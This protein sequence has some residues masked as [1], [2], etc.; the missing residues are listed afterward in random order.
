MLNRLAVVFFCVVLVLTSLLF[1]FRTRAVFKRNPWVTTFF[2]FLW[3]A[4]LGGCIALIVDVFT[5]VPVNTVTNTPQLCIDSGIN[6]FAA[7]V[8]IIP[9][10]NDTLIFLAT[11]WRL[12]R[13]SYADP[14]TLESGIK[15]FILG[16]HLPVFSKV[17][18]RDGQ[19]YYLLALFPDLCPH[20]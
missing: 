12:S 16:D 18:L 13:N 5:P 6:P 4:V 20:V 8:T 17:L 19:A 11:T 10:I 14:Y 7:T 3:L 9:L 2:A 1:L 15:I